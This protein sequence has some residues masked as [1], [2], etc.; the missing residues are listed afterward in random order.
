MIQERVNY[1][2]QPLY[3]IP[4]D[5]KYPEKI[6]IRQLFAE[7]KVGREELL[8]V[9]SASYHAPGTCTF[10]GTAN[11]NQMLMEIMGLQLPGSSFVNPDTELRSLLNDYAVKTLEELCQN[12]NTKVT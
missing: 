8:A 5:L 2:A 11:T 9:E 12:L 7:G 6:K 4:M 3:R 10:Y 1:H